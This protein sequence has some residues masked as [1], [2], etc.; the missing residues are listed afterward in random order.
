MPYFIICPIY[1]ILFTGGIFLGLGFWVRPST[2]PYSGI[3]LSGTLGT[4][5]GF[6]VGNILFWAISIAILWLIYFPLKFLETALPE[7]IFKIIELVVGIPGLI[8]LAAGLLFA[9]IIGCL[10][11]FL[12]GC[13]L[14]D[15]M[16]QRLSNQ[17]IDQTAAR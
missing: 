16:R 2:R 15:Y 1:A 6:I 4:I 3:V 5:P 13:Y 8:A 14:I 17:G 9:N 12:A 7:N 11:G 10:A